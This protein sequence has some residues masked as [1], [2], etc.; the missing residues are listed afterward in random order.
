MSAL[1]AVR[2]DQNWLGFAIVTGILVFSLAAWLRYLRVEEGGE[3]LL[4]WLRSLGPD[5]DADHVECADPDCDLVICRCRKPAECIGTTTLGCDHEGLCWGCRLGC[6]E[7]AADE[8]V[9]QELAWGR[10]R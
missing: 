9:A 10:G 8:A 6:R 4:T 2:N 7:C 1:V 3:E 5:L